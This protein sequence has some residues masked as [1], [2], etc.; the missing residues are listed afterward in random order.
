[1][2]DKGLKRTV[3]PLGRV[4][5]PKEIRKDLEIVDGE[6]QLAITV[7]NDAIVLRNTRLSVPKTLDKAIVIID[8]ELEFAKQVNPQMAMGMT[9]IKELIE[10]ELQGVQP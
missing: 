8:Q 7:E 1:M 2:S 10:R 6:T 3:D 9:R 4:V 5:L